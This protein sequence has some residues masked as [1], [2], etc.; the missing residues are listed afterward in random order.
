MLCLL[1]N[2]YRI[3]WFCQH[4]QSFHIWLGI[5]TPPK[6]CCELIFLLP[7][8]KGHKARVATPSPALLLLV[9]V[10]IRTFTSQSIQPWTSL[11]NLEKFHLEV[12]GRQKSKT[13]FETLPTGPFNIF[14]IPQTSKYAEYCKGQ[15]RPCHWQKYPNIPSGYYPHC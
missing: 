6:K 2:I 7:P 5:P 14:I 9:S 10:K 8:I 1:I 11:A 12:G 3:S 13:V 15:V 4:H